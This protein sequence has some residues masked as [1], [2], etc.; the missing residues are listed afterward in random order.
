MVDSTPGFAGEL[1]DAFAAVS[2]P[3]RVDILREL[4]AHA[5][6]TEAPVCRF[7]E[8]RERVG[9]DD[10]GRFRYHLDKLVGRYVERTDDGYQLTYAG[11]EIVAAILA[12]RYTSHEPV[13]PTQLDSECPLCGSTVVGTYENRRLDVHCDGGHALLSW[14]LPPNAAVDATADDLARLATSLVLHA[15]DL[16][17][18]GVCSQC[19][20]P[21]T[22][23]IELDDDE[24]ETS[25]PGFRARCAVCV[26][27]VVGP[28]WF[29]IMV[30]PAVESFYHAH[31]RPIRNAQLWELDQ[32]EYEPTPAADDGVRLV[33]TLDDEVLCVTLS[34]TGAVLDTRVNSV[35]ERQSNAS[36]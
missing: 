7:S 28:A 17:L 32:V 34:E 14:P 16:S 27:V 4:V 11:G 9:V 15:V 26:G 8:L 22:T 3:V 10:P 24:R 6:E 31:G 2:D 18:K 5:R 13:G 30:H 36:S 1:D 35:E 20:G 19:Y 25:M 29:P 23:Q 21:M 12:G 33:V